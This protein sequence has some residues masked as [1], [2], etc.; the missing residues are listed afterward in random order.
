MVQIGAW[1][2]IDSR[3][4]NPITRSERA[5]GGWV[6]DGGAGK[7]TLGIC[8]SMTWADGKMFRIGAWANEGSHASNRVVG[9]EWAG[10]WV[11][12]GDVYDPRAGFSCI[13]NGI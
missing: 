7:N 11:V 8:V 2:N 1:A 4:G 3:V 10:N 6:V 12:D 9:I 5:R 13:I